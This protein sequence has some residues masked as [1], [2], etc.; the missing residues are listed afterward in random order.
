MPFPQIKDL[1]SGSARGIDNLLYSADTFFSCFADLAL[2][3]PEEYFRAGSGSLM[4]C[5]ITPAD[6]YLGSTNESIAVET[7]R[8]VTGGLGGCCWL[9]CPC[10]A[11]AVL[12]CVH[13][14]LPMWRHHVCPAASCVAMMA[15]EPTG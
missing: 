5:V 12:I 4:Q 14:R 11:A 3:S 6:K 8:Q 9:A 1:S 10:L 13:I 15:A 7:D 2:T